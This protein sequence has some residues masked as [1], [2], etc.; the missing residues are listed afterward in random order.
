MKK[1]TLI[2][3]VL[4]LITFSGCGAVK[5]LMTY[6]TDTSLDTVKQVH[7]L[8]M[9]NSVGFEWKKI[10]DKRIH[11]VNIY[12]S[13]DSDGREG[14]KRIGTVGNRYATHFVDTHVKADTTYRYTFST[15]AFGQES[16]RSAPLEVRTLRAFSAV[17]FVKA[18]KVDPSVVKLLWKPHADPSISTYII[19]RSVN[20]SEW[21]FVS[22]VQGQLMVE[23]IDTFV[24]SGNTYSY[25]IIAQSYDKIRAYPSHATKI[26][27]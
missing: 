23:Y 3:W 22:Q 26:R 14:F 7:A 20:G 8:P 25:R 24:R 13:N 11:G 9:M 18:Y 17:S 10:E 4:S 19:E 12:R 27:L 21:K 2:L 6:G 16:K 5:G 15:F 1:S